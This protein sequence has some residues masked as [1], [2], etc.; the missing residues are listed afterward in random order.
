MLQSVFTDIERR[1]AQVGNVSFSKAEKN[2]N[3]MASTLAIAG[4]KR[5]D[6]FKAWCEVYYDW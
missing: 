3:E 6:I 4:I 2:G 5:P 1:M